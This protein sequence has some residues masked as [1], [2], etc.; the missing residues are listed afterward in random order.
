MK[1]KKVLKQYGATEEIKVYNYS[2]KSNNKVIE[3]NQY[4]ISILE[5]LPYLNRKVIGIFTNQDENEPRRV[6]TRIDIKPRKKK[7]NKRK[8]QN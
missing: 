5:A 6:Y 8:A 4:T 3:G 7:K 2:G 1:L